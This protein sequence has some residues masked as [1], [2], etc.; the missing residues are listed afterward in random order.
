MKRLMSCSLLSLLLG[1]GVLAP[2]PLYAEEQP[3]KKE[4][5][6]EHKDEHKKDKDEKARD[7]E[8]KAKSVKG[9][10]LFGYW[11]K[12][13]T[14]SPETKIKIAEIHKKALDAKNEIEAREEAEILSLLN[15]EQK[16]ELQKLKEEEA[17]A[18]KAKKEPAGKKDGESKE[19]AEKGGM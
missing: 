8:E 11:A 7:K 6:K 10:R 12:M 1:L 17:A 13:T 19:K 16:L 15:D 5:D 18:R 3:E 2:A 14:L 9:P 4:H